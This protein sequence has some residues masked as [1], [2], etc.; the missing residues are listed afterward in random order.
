MQTLPQH[1]GQTVGAKPPSAFV[2]GVHLCQVRWLEAA[3]AAHHHVLLRHN[4]NLFDRGGIAAPLHRLMK[5]KMPA[6]SVSFTHEELAQRARA[7]ALDW[8]W[9]N[10]EAHHQYLIENSSAQ[11]QVIPLLKAVF[12][13]TPVL[14]VSRDVRDHIADRLILMDYTHS[15]LPKERVLR[16]VRMRYMALEWAAGVR[17]GLELAHANPDQIRHYRLEAPPPDIAAEARAVLAFCGIEAD[18]AMIS[19]AVAMASAPAQTQCL[20][21]VKLAET[22]AWRQ[23]LNRH[24]LAQIHDVAGDLMVQLGYSWL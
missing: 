2:V 3:F 9:R 10:S 21:E 13:E 11:A 6:F 17:A 24:D 22:G 16:N 19:R 15:L 14:L 20:P 7:V 23:M 4:Y 8:Y 12:P 5:P 18:E 1:Q